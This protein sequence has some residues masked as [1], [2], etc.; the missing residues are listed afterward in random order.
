MSLLNQKFKLEND[1]HIFYI[2]H[3]EKISADIFQEFLLELPEQ[4]QKD[5]RA[6]KHWE[7]AQAS[8]LGKMLLSY[9]LKKLHLNY[10]LQD[11]QVGEKDRPFIND[12]IDFNIS[13]S[14]EYV[15]C[16]ITQH[17]KVGID[18]EKHR[19]LKYNIAGR[20]FNEFECNEIIGSENP[21]KTF[22]DFW[23][24]KE[25]AIKCDGRGV[26]V[27]SETHVLSSDTKHLLNSDELYCDH[28]KFYFQQLDIEENYACCI[29]S[30]SRFKKIPTNLNIAELTKS[31]I[32]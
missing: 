32:N 3:T 16:A 7:S 5:I 9:G 26:E 28:Q 21:Q 2:K 11:I 8:L 20:Y 27:L 15:I 18:I 30:N 17:A 31:L 6:Y 29:C 1:I 12:K 25:S 13:H 10:S 24:I 4:F 14:G 23:S 22:F 19:I